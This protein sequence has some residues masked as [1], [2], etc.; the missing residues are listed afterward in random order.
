MKKPLFSLLF[1]VAAAIFLS[2]CSRGITIHE[3]ANGKAKCGRYV[4]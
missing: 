4:R 2:S 1:I 3:A